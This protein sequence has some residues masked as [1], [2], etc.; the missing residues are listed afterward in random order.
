M[1]IWTIAPGTAMPA[2]GRQVPER[3]VDAHAEHQQDDP[4]VGQLERD[5]GVRAEARGERAEQDAGHDV[6]DDRRQADTLRDEAAHECGHQADRDGGDE[7]GLV[8]HGSPR[9]SGWAQDWRG[10]VPEQRLGQSGNDTRGWP[11]APAEIGRPEVA[12]ARRMFIATA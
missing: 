5:L 4:D 3:E 10:S 11:R 7:Y 1:T 6:A 2:D 12:D 8:V 9:P